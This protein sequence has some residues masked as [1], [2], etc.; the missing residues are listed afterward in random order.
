MAGTCPV[1]VL[2]AERIWIDAVPRKR[3]APRG[4]SLWLVQQLAHLR[5]LGT[6]GPVLRPNQHRLWYA[7]FPGDFGGGRSPDMSRS[8]SRL[9]GGIRLAGRTARERL[10]VGDTPY[11]VE[12]ARR[13]RVRRNSVRCGRWDQELEEADTVADYPA[14]LLARYDEL[15]PDP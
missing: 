9:L 7:D 12:G 6:V 3:Q 11:D 8:P 1:A 15:F 5:S 14:E 10:V 4:H 2:R 13:A